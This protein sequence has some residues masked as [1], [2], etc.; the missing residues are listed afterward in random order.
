MDR[1]DGRTMGMMTL[2]G[3]A[4]GGTAKKT[5]GTDRLSGVRY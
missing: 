5:M 1:W 4:V 3:R 2:L